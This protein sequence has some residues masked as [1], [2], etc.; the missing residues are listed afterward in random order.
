MTSAEAVSITMPAVTGVEQAGTSPPRPSRLPT[1]QRRQP[2]YGVSR[3]SSHSVGTR[4]PSARST[5]SSRVPGFACTGRPSTL[6]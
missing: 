3:S 2:P 1:T 5:S 6:S 4:T